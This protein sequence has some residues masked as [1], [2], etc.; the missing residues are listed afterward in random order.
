V[1]PM[2]LVAV[3]GCCTKE[4][5]MKTMW[6]WLWSQYWI[7]QNYKWL[8]PERDEEL[9]NLIT[10]PEFSGLSEAVVECWKRM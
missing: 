8:R 5:E 4:K 6:I 3:S 9:Y 2:A 10:N 1:A 7:G